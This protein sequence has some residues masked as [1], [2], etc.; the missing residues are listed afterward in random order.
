MFLMNKRAWR[1]YS[2]IF[3][4]WLGL[5]S[6]NDGFSTD[7]SI[8]DNLQWCLHCCSEKKHLSNL[9]NCEQGLGWGYSEIMMDFPHF[10]HR[11]SASH[12]D[13]TS[14]MMMIKLTTFMN[15][16]L[17]V[18]IYIT[19]LHNLFV[20]KTGVSGQKTTIFVKGGGRG[21]DALQAKSFKKCP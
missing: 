18:Q 1:G 10:F 6:H 20:D 17:C 3:T 2:D 7:Q 12:C 5:F 13:P 14:R 16:F 8:F 21:G 19:K 15:I 4:T 9:S 11:L